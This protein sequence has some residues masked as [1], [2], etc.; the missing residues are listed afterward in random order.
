MPA[1]M[2]RRMPIPCYMR[3]PLLQWTL[4]SRSSR[5]KRLC[6][7]GNKGAKWWWKISLQPQQVLSIEHF[8]ILHYVTAV[9]STDYHSFVLN[10]L[11]QSPWYLNNFFKGHPFTNVGT[12]TGVSNLKWI[13]FLPHQFLRSQK[14]LNSSQRGERKPPKQAS[15]GPQKCWGLST[16]QEKTVSLNSSFHS[17]IVKPSQSKHFGQCQWFI[18]VKKMQWT[19]SSKS[20]K[21]GYQERIGWEIGTRNKPCICVYLMWSLGAV[22]WLDTIPIKPKLTGNLSL[23]YQCSWQF[24]VGMCHLVLQILTL[25]QTW[26]LRNYVIITWNR[27]KDFL[28][29][30]LIWPIIFLFLSH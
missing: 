2:S 23:I 29:S 9:N 19:I 28:R 24:L 11:S 27:K 3:R 20:F 21:R 6:W 1:K 15:G 22:W 17:S 30:T 10:R 4:C 16:K 7:R 5:D 8:V 26:P 25:F 14:Q 18:D 13:I 12:I